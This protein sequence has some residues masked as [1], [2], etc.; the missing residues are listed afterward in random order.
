MKLHAPGY[1]VESQLDVGSQKGLYILDGG[2]HLLPVRLTFL[3]IATRFAPL[4]FGRDGLLDLPCIERLCIGLVIDLIVVC[5]LEHTSLVS[6][7]SFQVHQ[8]VIVITD[9]VVS[10]GIEELLL[11]QVIITIQLVAHYDVQP[12][13]CSEEQQRVRVGTRLLAELR[14]T[15]ALQNSITNYC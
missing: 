9:I 4:T 1:H 15:A 14:H 6:T 5:Q 10:L 8:L 11:V 7:T 13:S 12:L 3:R 2:I